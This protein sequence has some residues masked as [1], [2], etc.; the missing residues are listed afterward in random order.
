VAAALSDWA[1]T[2]SWE[3]ASPKQIQTKL[4]RAK[5]QNLVFIQFSN[6]KPQPVHSEYV[7]RQI[8]CLN[9][10]KGI[11][12]CH[13]RR[14]FESTENET[15]VYHRFHSPAIEKEP[16]MKLSQ[17]NQNLTD[18]QLNTIENDLNHIGFYIIE[19]VI[20]AAEADQVRQISLDLA[21]EDLM[22]GRDHSYADGKCR[23][24]W[25]IVGKDPI[26]RRLIQHPTIIDAWKHILG[27][28][29]VAST[30]TANIVYPGA[31]SSGW[32][33]DYP[34]WAMES[35]FPRGALTGQTVWMID[36]FTTSNGA[37]ACIKGSHQTL[38]P[39]DADQISQ[40]EQ[41]IAVAPK[42]SVMLTNGAIWHRSTANR[43]NQ[44]RV[45]LLGMYNRSVILP[46]EDMP[47]QL[48]DPEL[49]SESDLLKQLLGRQVDY[50]SPDLSQTRRRTATGFRLHT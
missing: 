25:A 24:V 11:F 27:N 33:V 49:E 26:F 13:N 16:L 45:G 41:A 34:Y 44:L 3:I 39:P 1:E 30:F 9:I 50:R 40:M 20:S 8:C 48:T 31:E 10:E 2:K 21:E 7:G 37:T 17:P 38:S 36:D 32:H 28:D 15:E 18:D 42:G 35:P 23:R 46:Q 14:K 12:V 29:V 19:N 43:T 47:S 22:N 5:N 6:L 4:T